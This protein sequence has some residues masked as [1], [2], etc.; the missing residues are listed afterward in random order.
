[1]LLFF[2]EIPSVYESSGL[3]TLLPKAYANLASPEDTVSAQRTA[4]RSDTTLGVR[5]IS[6][7]VLLV[8]RFLLLNRLP[9]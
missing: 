8:S 4:V 2:I 1:M 5:K 6:S 9:R 7:S 3:I